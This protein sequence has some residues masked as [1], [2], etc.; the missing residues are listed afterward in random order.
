MELMV[1]ITVGLLVI[2][3]A[4]L[5]V[6]SQLAENRR[7]L[8]ETQVQQDLRATADIIVRELRRA[9]HWRRAEA[10]VASTSNGVAER[11]DY[12]SVGSVG[13]TQCSGS[14]ANFDIC[15]NYLRPLGLADAD[16]AG[17]PSY[18][19]GYWLTGG[20]IKT[21]LSTGAGTVQDLTDV[22]VLRVLSLRVDLNDGVF[23]PT[24]WVLLPCP[25]LCPPNNTTD[26]WP[27]V[28][29]RDVTIT[30][31]G[32]AVSDRSVERTVVS[33][34]RLRNDKVQFRAGAAADYQACPA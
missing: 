14:L 15:F 23:D 32:Q 9:G 3:G 18:T 12:M 26:C 8:L 19:F 30:I 2:A 31:T 6:S 10:G 7:L 17:A 28:A 11:N 5:L 16:V 27:R 22:R 29:M 24:R 21:K 1:G 4:S 20:V 34:V 25:K 33:R 13:N